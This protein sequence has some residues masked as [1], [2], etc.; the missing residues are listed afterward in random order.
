MLK[1]ILLYRPHLSFAPFHVLVHCLIAFLRRLPWK[2]LNSADV[3]G[4]TVM[5]TGVR[6]GVCVGVVL[7]APSLSFGR[8]ILDNVAHAAIGRLRTIPVMFGQRPDQERTDSRSGPVR[9]AI[10]SVVRSVEMPDSCVCVHEQFR[11]GRFA[12]HTSIAFC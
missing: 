5:W 9:A 8:Q 10:N 7:K 2:S 4:E 6:R 1:T 12:H 11:P 3:E